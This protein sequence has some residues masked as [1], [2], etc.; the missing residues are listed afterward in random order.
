M[1]P[2]G[3]RSPPEEGFPD[4]GALAALRAWHE[5]VPARQAVI[6]YL[7]DKRA[8]GA[9]S[10]GMLT[11]VR[12]QL[13]AYARGRQQEA[14]AKLFEAPGGQS[15]AQARAVADAIE[16]L[17]VL[18]MP[19]PLIGDEVSRWLPLRIA[20]AL[21][22]CGIT[23]LAQ[24]TVRVP[25]RRRWWA[26]I[27]GLGQA[28]A[29]RVEAFFAQHPEL[30]ERARALTLRDGPQL[31]VP[32]ESLSMPRE[33]DG[34][35]GLFR[36][37]V[38]SCILRASND[39]EAVNAWLE[40]H[41]AEATKKAY[42]KE[43]ERLILWS[44]VERGCALSSL[45]TEDAIA[46][47]S[48]LRRPTPSVRWVGP[49]RPRT[50]PEWRPFAAALSPR[51]TGYALSVLGALFR[52]LIAQR[53]VLANPFAGVKARGARSDSAFDTSRAFTEGEWSLIRAV[54]EGLEYTHG[55]SL[56]AAQRLR[57]ILDFDYATGLR[58]GELVG[59]A[60]GQIKS[61]GAGD[62]WLHL[63]GKGARSGKVAM[64]PLARGALE[65]YL[66]Q[67]GLPTLQP[68]W[69]PATPIL[70]SLEGGGSIS[71]SRLRAVIDRFCETAAEA[72][73]GEAP[74]LAEKLRRASPH[75]MRHTHATHALGRGVELTT[76]RDNLRHA[77][78]T[79][80]STYLHVD[81][82]KRARQV[83]DAFGARS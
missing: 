73:A 56:Q 20:R 55:W 39:Y 69:N 79:T 42:R 46:Y 53:Y 68:H 30:T 9:S 10:R 75:W 14:L 62:Q 37:P 2:G 52:W 81:D 19:T 36:A 44:V 6:R 59:Q 15:V 58:A 11:R 7:G 31:L 4:A 16:Q 23:T 1:S 76:V 67:R 43:A 3:H 74:A 65:R 83:G 25:R 48:F 40:L 27:E 45:T 64:P 41:E 66:A 35:A 28:G 32:W 63:V 8:T 60:L 61:D 24:L 29:R 26:A 70:A 5:G 78:V 47:R 18:Q 38:G 13:S 34:S 72:I 57:F 71:T 17:R 49:A 33:L 12:R 77:S 82:A 51:S 21:N 80:T 22:D 54:A 50:S